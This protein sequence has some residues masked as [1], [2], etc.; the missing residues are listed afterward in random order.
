MVGID[1]S[2]GARE[3]G[4]KGAEEQRRGGAREQRS[5]GAEGQRSGGEQ[6]GLVRRLITF[7]PRA[8]HFRIVA[9]AIFLF[10]KESQVAISRLIS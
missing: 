8:R 10:G 4:G 5:R 6:L 3:R 1:E 7:R 9:Q 2:T